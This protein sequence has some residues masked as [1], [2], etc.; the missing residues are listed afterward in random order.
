[1]RPIAE[2]IFTS[3]LLPAL[4]LP[5]VWM[6]RAFARGRVAA[7]TPPVG[8]AR[9]LAIHGGLAASLLI[10]CGLAALGVP[11]ERGGAPLTLI[12]WLLFAALHFSFAALASA[13]TSQIPAAS[14]DGARDRLFAAFVLATLLQPAGTAAGL[15]VLYRLMRL[16]YHQTLP[17]FDIVPEGI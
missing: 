6:A 16:V 2:V 13:A 10:A 12:S 11:I 4:L 17:L 3:Y 14:G 1:M 5:L 9:W 8:L 7:P 15:V